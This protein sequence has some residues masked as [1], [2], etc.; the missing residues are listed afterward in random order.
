MLVLKCYKVVIA[1]NA[2][3]Q[4]R[5]F[6]N[7]RFPSLWFFCPLTCLTVSLQIGVYLAPVM[8]LVKFLIQT[9]KSLLNTKNCTWNLIQLTNRVC[10]KK[11]N[12]WK[13]HI[14]LSAPIIRSLA[15][16]D[17][18]EP[19]KAR[20]GH[21]FQCIKVLSKETDIKGYKIVTFR[22]VLFSL[23]NIVI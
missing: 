21:S 8:R 18:F 16:P 17:Q 12:G 15:L 1:I 9:N 22:P 3:L 10:I 23:S 5:H 11:Y 2:I 20:R 13:A 6:V 14:M 7:V 19:S 4:E